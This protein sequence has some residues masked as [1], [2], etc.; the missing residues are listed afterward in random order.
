[1]ERV[2]VLVKPDGVLQGLAGEVLERFRKAGLHLVGGPKEVSP[3]RGILDEHY[4]KDEAW[5]ERL[6]RNIA[7]TYR[8]FGKDPKQYIH[9]D[10]PLE[11]GRL[12]RE[13]Y[14]DSMLSAPIVAAIFE[15]EDAVAIARAVAGHTR[16]SKAAPGTIRADFGREGMGRRIPIVEN[17]VHVS[18]TPE[19]AQREIA[20]WFPELSK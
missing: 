2:L 19:E 15:G 13:A 18:G 8:E 10:Y 3:D 6:G 5:I 4:P 12:S 16:P 11:I 20:L 9:T 7:A 1:V 14:I 17:V